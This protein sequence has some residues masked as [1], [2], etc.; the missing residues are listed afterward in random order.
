VADHWGV[1]AR[2]LWAEFHVPVALAVQVPH[3]FF[4]NTVASDTDVTDRALLREEKVVDVHAMYLHDAGNWR[5]VGFGGPSYFRLS[6]EMVE[7]VRYEQLAM[8][9]QAPIRSAS[10]RSTRPMCPV[11]PGA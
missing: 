6:H 8:S 5:I 11:P 1:G 2:A 9:S 3:P 4:L 10:P 7:S